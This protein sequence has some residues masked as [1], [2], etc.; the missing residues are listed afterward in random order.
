M[1]LKPQDLLVALKLWTGRNQRWTYPL[2][3]TSL[4]MSVSEAHGAVKRAVAAGLLTGSGLDSPPNADGLREFVIHGVK[5]AFPARPGEMTRGMPTAHAASPLR[6]LLVQADEP[7]PVWPHPEGS[8]RGQRLDPLFPSVPGA[9][10]KD[11]ALY[12][13]LALLDALRAGRARERQLAARILA[14]RLK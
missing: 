2:L 10:S 13:L 6:A 8:V 5:Y 11:P 14:E 12:E 1:P 7:P 9:A 4:G 3:A